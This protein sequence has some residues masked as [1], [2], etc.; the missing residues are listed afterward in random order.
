[1]SQPGAVEEVMARTG[2]ANA[3]RAQRQQFAA[4]VD[5]GSQQRQASDRAFTL[6]AGQAAA[7]MFDPYT[8]MYGRGGGSAQAGQYSGP[9]EF[10]PYLGAS[11]SVAADNQSAAEAAAAAANAQEFAKWTMKQQMAA[12]KEN[13]RMNAAM[14]QRTNASN[15]RSGLIGS[16][17]GVVGNILSSFI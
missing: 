10:Q 11:A 12:E 1:M 14:D 4:G 8:R 16:G 5:T 6:N 15:R 9:Q 2:A 7:A 17:I 3:R 13:F